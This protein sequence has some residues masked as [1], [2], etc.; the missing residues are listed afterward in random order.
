M[1]F[2][3][4]YSGYSIIP[5][6][7]DS[8][9]SASLV[10]TCIFKGMGKVNAASEARELPQRDRLSELALFTMVIGMVHQRMTS[11]QCRTQNRHPCCLQGKSQVRGRLH[12]IVLWVWKPRFGYWTKRLKPS[13]VRSP[14]ACRYKCLGRAGPCYSS[15]PVAPV[16]SKGQKG[17]YKSHDTAWGFFPP[18]KLIGCKL[19][20]FPECGEVASCTETHFADCVI[21]K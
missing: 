2:F 21:S 14:A 18:K 16:S 1:I 4:R 11:Y 12:R 5:T 7:L 6:S 3:A 10:G 17:S 9:F 15:P 8:R 13:L 19:K 20:M